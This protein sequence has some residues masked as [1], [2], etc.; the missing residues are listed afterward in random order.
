MKEIISKINA[1]GC[2]YIGAD[3]VPDLIK[4]NNLN[5]SNKNIQ[6]LALDLIDDAVPTV[7]LILTRDCFLHLSYKNIYK[8]LA[9][10]KTSNS[11]YLLC[12]T[13]NYDFRKNTNVKDFYIYGRALNMEK[14]PFY[15]TKPL[16]LINEDCTE[17][18]GAYNDKSLGLWEMKDI[19]LFKISVGIKLQAIRLNLWR[20]KHKL[21]KKN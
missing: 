6:F 2:L 7:D 19:S 20:L 3:I 14:F 15:F 21:L 9:N 4:E 13:Y 12:S 18:D 8:I 11:R 10:Y 17:G 5:F 16:V 1:Q